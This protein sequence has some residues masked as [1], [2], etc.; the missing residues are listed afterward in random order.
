MTL[1]KNCFEDRLFSGTIFISILL[2]LALLLLL[3][4]LKLIDQVEVTEWLEVDLIAPLDIDIQP[5]LE[6]VSRDING[7]TEDVSQIGDSPLFP[8]PPVWLPERMNAIESE[9]AAMRL[10]IPSDQIPE[11]AGTGLSFPGNLLGESTSNGSEGAPSQ[12][13]LNPPDVGWKPMQTTSVTP[14]E[15]DFSEFQISGEVADRRV[16]FRPP[17]PKPSAIMSGTVILKFWVHPN[18]T[19]GKILPVTRSD[20]ELERV[21]MTFFEKFRFEAVS[22]DIGQQTGTIP[23][24]FRIK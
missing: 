16:V 1:C 19:I 23:I 3:P 6:A 10:T 12:L 18:G 22:P 11:M 13:G 15:T 7:G 5:P 24:R 8:S 17:P 4:G 14:N 21:A 9:P 20:P 2:H